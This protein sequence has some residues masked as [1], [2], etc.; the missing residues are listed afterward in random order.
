MF[1]QIDKY[2][3]VQLSY[4]IVVGS[5]INLFVNS[6]ICD[7][8]Q[9]F[10]TNDN[11]RCLF[12]ESINSPFLLWKFY[13]DI[14]CSIAFSIC[15]KIL[16]PAFLHDPNSNCRDYTVF[17][18]GNSSG[19]KENRVRSILFWE[20]V[21]FCKQLT[22]FSSLSVNPYYIIDVFKIYQRSVDFDNDYLEIE[23]GKHE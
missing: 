3:L 21:T 13:L 18:S 7:K 9:L 11:F 1:V 16:S 20:T 15:N 17:T 8:Q 5:G 4:G 10:G 12:Y 2:I 19:L 14:Q 6:T 22:E 23:K